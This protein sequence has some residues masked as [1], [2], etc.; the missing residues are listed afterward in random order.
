M[1]KGELDKAQR[2]RTW[3]VYLDY[4]LV[5]LIRRGSPGWWKA[6]RYGA[7][8]A[9]N[10]YIPEEDLRAATAKDMLDLGGD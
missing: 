8:N 6:I 1:T 2:D 7:R 5:R 10:G 4:C 9:G 3:L